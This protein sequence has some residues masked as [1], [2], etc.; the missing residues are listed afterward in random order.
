MLEKNT[1]EQAEMLEE[2]RMKTRR[3]DHFKKGVDNLLNVSERS[4]GIRTNKYSLVL[5]TWRS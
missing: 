5:A 2:S 3:G 4:V 1:K